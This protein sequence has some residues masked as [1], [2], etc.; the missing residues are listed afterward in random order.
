[1]TDPPRSGFAGIVGQILS[2]A[3]TPVKAAILIVIAAAG[4]AG[5]IVYQHHSEIVENWMTP[6]TPTLK[7]GL[8]PAALDKLA[9]ETGADLVQVWS[10]DL[11]SNSQTF[12]AA[13]RKDGERPVIPSPRRLPLITTTT[14]A[15]GLVDVLNG[16]PTCLDLAPAGSPLAERL[17]HRGMTRGCAIPIPVS[18]EYLLGAV[19]LAWQIAPDAQT[20]S[21]AVGVARD[22]ART[23]ATR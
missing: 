13:R 2:Y 6:D 21:V 15:K 9:E 8:I 16:S 3:D 18:G 14:D 19:Y 1:M 10:V 11:S 5:W 12:F 20:E 23:L 17:A 4:G 22:I 7:T